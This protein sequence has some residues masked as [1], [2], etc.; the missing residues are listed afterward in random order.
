[1]RNF[2][3]KKS[4]RRFTERSFATLII[5]LTILIPTLIQCNQATAAIRSVVIEGEA[6]PGF[7]AGFVFQDFAG[8][9]IAINNSGL[10]VFIAKVYDG[11]TFYHT[12]WRE[13][14]GTAELIARSEENAPGISGD[15]LFSVFRH[16][17][18]NDAGQVAF[19]GQ[20]Q[21]SDVEMTSDNG[22]WKGT[23]GSLL[24][25][26]REGDPAPGS[27]G[28][29]FGG[30]FYGAIGDDVAL[31]NAG[32]VAFS[33]NLNNSTSASVWQENA[34]GLTLLAKPGEAVPGFGD[35]TYG[36]SVPGILLNNNGDLAF[37]PHIWGTFD[38]AI[39]N[40]YLVQTAVNGNVTTKYTGNLTAAPG[41]AGGVFQQ[42]PPGLQQYDM[43]ASGQLV[44]HAYLEYGGAVDS[45]N[46]SGIW[47]DASGSL[48]LVAR[49]GSHAPGTPA[50]AVFDQ[51]GG[52]IVMNDSGQVAFGAYLKRGAGG[53]DYTNSSGFWLETDGVLSLIAREGSHAPGTP[54]GVVFNGLLDNFSINGVGQIYFP[55][56]VTG[57]GITISNAA[58]IWLY[59]PSNGLTLVVRGGDEVTLTSG[60]TVTLNDIEIISSGYCSGG[61]DGRARYFNNSGEIVFGATVMPGYR[62][63][64]FISNSATNL[65]VPDIKANGSDGPVTVSSGAPVSVT[66]GLNPG[67]K[68]G[69]NADWWIAVKTPFAPPL[70][71]YTYV[72]LTGWLPG[73]NLYAQTG[74]FDLSSYEV[75]NMKLPVG[76][77]TF[78]FAI[79]DPDGAAT[80]PWWG[81]DSVVVTVQ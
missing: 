7:A 76:N 27:S 78:Y 63:G 71:W 32:R 15:V 53:V 3:Q 43:N 73:I 11:Y 61:S 22:V 47:S 41:V 49:Q 69:Q 51:F 74:L 4:V 48:A 62:D 65:P 52:S 55:A 9:R 12:L 37:F 25:V 56:Y 21:G 34:S 70:D 81:L 31:N 60:E 72:N 68:A 39:S 16:P 23:P 45:T 17:N 75:L 77:Y 42:F 28:D 13:N 38:W 2:N 64:F 5:C 19:V 30:S 66:I 40:V 58:G 1:M 10:T 59:D 18:I 20:L 79:D 67:N 80:G 29:T 35:A 57:P 8:Q 33:N 50:G 54:D 6:A 24:L 46:Q 26:A 14:S 44:F 36:S